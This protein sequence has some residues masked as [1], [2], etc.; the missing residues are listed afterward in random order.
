M[1]LNREYWRKRFAERETRMLKY[2]KDRAKETPD[3][4]FMMAAF[5][6]GRE[7]A[8]RAMTRKRGRRR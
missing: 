7:S 1:S 3:G 8:I 2:F 4:S 6:L 5:L